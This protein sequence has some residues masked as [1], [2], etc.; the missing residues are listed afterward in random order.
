MFEGLSGN[1]GIYPVCLGLQQ[2]IYNFDHN[3]LTGEL[4]GIKYADFQIKDE[5]HCLDEEAE[6]EELL[7][8]VRDP[9]LNFESENDSLLEMGQRFL[10]EFKDSVAQQ[11]QDE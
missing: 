11:L 9:F 2:Q 4:S 6:I 8:Q 1:T 3:V 7:L 5:A 10:V